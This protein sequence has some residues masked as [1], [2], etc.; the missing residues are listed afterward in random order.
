M[1]FHAESRLRDRQTDRQT[2]RVILSKHTI[3]EKRETKAHVGQYDI[4][5]LRD[6][7]CFLNKF[8]YKITLLCIF[9]R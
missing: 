3:W 4:L 1:Y 7:T 2:D 6:K 5:E 9:K 8:G